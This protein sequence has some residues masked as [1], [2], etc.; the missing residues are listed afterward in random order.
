[1]LL[2]TDQRLAE[3][4]DRAELFTTYGDRDALSGDDVTELLAEVH[5][6]HMQVAHLV[7]LHT[8][9]M[10][11]FGLMGEPVPVGVVWERD[12]P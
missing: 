1:M 3:L 4:R 11:R 10:D 8:R 5:A 2:M 7:A 9:D 6:C 12:Q